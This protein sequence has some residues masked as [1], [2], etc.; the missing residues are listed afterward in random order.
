[1]KFTITE[2]NGISIHL[3]IDNE[4]GEAKNPKLVTISKEGYMGV[5]FDIQDHHYCRIYPECNEYRSGQG[6]ATNQGFKLL[7]IEP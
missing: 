3:Q 5:P 7:E 1:M 2:K 4:N 6:I